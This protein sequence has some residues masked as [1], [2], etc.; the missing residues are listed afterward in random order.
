M[1]RVATRYAFFF[2]L[3]VLLLAS[4]LFLFHGL[5]NYS[6]KEPDEGRYAE[7]PR[8]MVESG[9]YIVPYLNYSRYFEK[10]PLLYWSV[11]LSYKA[12]GVN[13]WAFRFPNALSAFFTCMALFLLGRRWFGA[14]P[15]FLSAIILVS[16]I[17]LFSMGRVVTTDMLL[18]FWLFLS[19]LSFYGYYREKSSLF[20]YTFYISL[21]FATLTKGPIAVVLIIVSIVLFLFTERRLSF[22][23]DLKWKTGLPLFLVI[24]APWFVLITLREPAFFHFFFIDQHL[25]RFLTPK[26]KR[27]GPLYYFAPILFGGLF[28][29]SFFIPRSIGRLWSRSEFRLF[30]I[31]SLIV[32]FFFSF[33]KSKLPPYILP[34]FPS[35]AL[36]LGSFF[37]AA[38]QEKMKVP[39]R[40]VYLCIFCFVSIVTFLYAAG[41]LDRFATLVAP[42]AESPFF[43]GARWFV[44][45]LSVLSLLAVI[46]FL[47]PRPSLSRAFSMLAC[48]SVFLMIGLLFN[49]GP[50]DKLR[51]TKGL[52][53]LIN[54][55]AAPSDIV[56]NYGSF[57]ETLPFYTKRPVYL[58]SHK[59]EL[60]MGSEYPDS[61]HRFLD[62]SEFI[63]LFNSDRRVFCVLKTKRL[64]HL[65]ELGIRGI[66]IGREGEKCLIYNR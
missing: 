2:H 16:S 5:G 19:L 49:L 65:A 13:E 29:W 14:F 66:E 52:A 56:V 41:L 31:W 8:E 61:V 6:L 33:S 15:A 51:T 21:S 1:K 59:G 53:S 36:M 20:I 64:P 35:V 37:A 62:D 4:Y 40:I 18:T 27:T 3:A 63:R 45:F 44:F 54:A 12:F 38:W 24:T 9:N 47:L 25:L 30:L 48:F 23:K 55:W 32:F 58:V 7:I 42:E 10:P 43:F 39:E 17:G 57:H 22:I 26:H 11:A 34:I 60:R 28:P 50:A 46:C